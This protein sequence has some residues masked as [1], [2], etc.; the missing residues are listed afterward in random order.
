MTV[1]VEISENAQALLIEQARNAG[2]SLEEFLSQTL[3]RAATASSNSLEALL[4]LPPE[5]L[6][7]KSFLELFEAIRG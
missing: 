3:E 6:R 5:R 4:A 2:L 1:T 7:E